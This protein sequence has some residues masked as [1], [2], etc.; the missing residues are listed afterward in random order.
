VRT[1]VH[2]D[3]VFEL[4]DADL[5]GCGVLLALGEDVVEVVELFEGFDGFKAWLGGVE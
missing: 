3:S 4:L 5:L 2:G 1:A